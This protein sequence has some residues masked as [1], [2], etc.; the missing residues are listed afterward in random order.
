MRVP[1]A[2]AGRAKL[3]GTKRGNDPQN[4]VDAS[5]H[6]QILHDIRPEKPVRTDDERPPQRSPEPLQQD[7]VILRNL[8]GEIG[9]ERVR[10][11][12]QLLV[13]P[14]HVGK[15]GVR[16]DPE[17]LRIYRR[18]FV[19][20]PG[21]LEDLRASYG[22]KVQRVEKQDD[23]LPPVVGEL[24]LPVLFSHDPRQL[25]RRRRAVHLDGHVR[26]SFSPTRAH[27]QRK[28]S[29]ANREGGG[30]KIPTMSSS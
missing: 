20:P 4:L 23:P 14:R 25:E 27:D 6:G 9:E 24:D 17:N 19:L 22:G 7:P 26:S 30:H 5:S 1:G 11:L 15:L 13:H 3:A 16:A 29:T 10:Q 12:P 2:P 21:E 18:E 28:S 8:L